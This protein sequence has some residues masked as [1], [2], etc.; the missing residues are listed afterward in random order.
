MYQRFFKRFLDLLGAILLSP[1][2]LP[3]IGV[4]ALLVRAT[5]P[6]P[7]FFKQ[8]RVGKDCR[9]FT[10]YKLRSMRTETHRNGVPLTDMERMTRVGNF[11]RKLSID[12]L[13]QLLNILNGSMS[14]IGPRPLLPQYIP[15]YNARQIRRHEAR[16]GITGWAQ[17]NGRNAVT[18]PARLEMDVYYVESLSPALDLR[19]IGRTFAYV[20]GSK[21]VNRSG[22][23][24]MPE[25]MGEE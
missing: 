20:F 1:I 15:R 7:A 19:V 21:G 6:G 25:F 3:V 14:F 9:L 18:W 2:A 8:T 10:I 5:S 11:L 17:V 23:E 12:E 4:A 16:P 13:P 24:T 22:G